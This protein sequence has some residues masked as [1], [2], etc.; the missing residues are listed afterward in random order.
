MIGAIVY[1]LTKNLTPEEIKKAGFDDILWPMYQRWI[2]G[3]L[4]NAPAGVNLLKWC[5][6]TI[7][8]ILMCGLLTGVF[9]TLRF[10]FA[11]I[12]RPRV[13][14]NISEYFTDYVHGHSLT[15]G[16]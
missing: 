2:V 6:P 9:S 1:Q 14:R 12:L 7:L 5:L 13:S 16:R 10:W 8:L 4:E 15:F 3:M 11:D